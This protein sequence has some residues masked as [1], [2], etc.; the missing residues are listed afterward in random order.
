MEGEVALEGMGPAEFEVVGEGVAGFEVPLPDE[1]AGGEAEPPPSRGGDQA[2]LGE[3]VEEVFH[4]GVVEFL[5][6]LFQ[7]LVLSS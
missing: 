4:A 3:R 6:H 1:A 7:F 2:V 5:V